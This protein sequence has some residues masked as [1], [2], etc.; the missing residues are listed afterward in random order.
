MLTFQWLDCA[1]YYQVWWNG[2]D[3]LNGPLLSGTGFY[4]KREALYGTAPGYLMNLIYQY[5]N[6]LSYLTEPL[7]ISPK[8]SP[9][10]ERYY[11]EY[12][13]QLV[14]LMWGIHLLMEE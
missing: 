13:D 8:N 3:G 12:V 2:C 1:I 5:F 9:Y 4:I 10:K 7:K 11:A 6:F 14:G